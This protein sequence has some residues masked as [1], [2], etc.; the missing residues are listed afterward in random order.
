MS[1]KRQFALHRAVIM[2]GILLIYF[3]QSEIRFLPSA[4]MEEIAGDLQVR[5]TTV[6]NLLSVCMVAAAICMF[7]VSV[8]VDRLGSV[9]LLILSAL[10]A[11]VSGFLASVA[12]SLPVALF[13]YIFCG[14]CQGTMECI[15]V[16]L[17]SQLFSARYRALF[18]GIVC[19]VAQISSSIAYTLPLF[20]EKTVGDWRRLEL[21]WGSL[22]LAV[23]ILLLLLGGRKT[24]GI[25]KEK[26]KKEKAGV[27]RALQNPFIVLSV[28]TMVV[29]I[30]VNNHY[31]IYLPT[32]LA[33]VKDFAKEQAG[34]TTSLMY[35]C[36]F[37]GALVAGV[38]GERLRKWI[39]RYAPLFMLV[40][41]LMLCLLKDNTGILVGAG[42][43]GFFYQMWIPMAM[44]SFMN[45]EGMQTAVLAGATAL[46]N[47]TGH[48]LTGFIPSIFTFKLGFMNMHIAY[49]VTTV[50]LLIPVLLTAV[51]SRLPDFQ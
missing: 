21:L 11:A 49:L 24:I 23:A 39:Y 33:S 3:F 40:G 32:Y 41:G 19:A 4:L 15:G 7:G 30:W 16:V 27:L 38:V 46:F 42:L 35:T 25:Q 34:L 51:A 48:F 20:L 12:P 2:L 31:A 50:F 36:G 45:L 29:F 9:N 1:T 47:G 6:G 18:C 5:V 8:V 13:A 37:L 43:F 28:F 10:S 14:M 44:A 17:V 26:H 22:I